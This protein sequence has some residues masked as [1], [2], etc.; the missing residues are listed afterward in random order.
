MKWSSLNCHGSSTHKSNLGPEQTVARR[1]AGFTLIEMLVVITIIGLLIALLLPAVQSARAT[2]RRIH[3]ANNLKQ[4]GTALHSFVNRNGTV[5]FDNGGT[6]RGFFGSLLPDLEQ[7]ALYNS[8]NAQ[9]GGADLPNTTSYSA[10]LAVFSCP[11]ETFIDNRS[12]YA[13]NAG[14]GFFSQGYDGIV[15]SNP[16]HTPKTVGFRDLTD[17]SSCTAAV[18]EWLFPSMEEPNPRRRMFVRDTI[19]SEVETLALFLNHCRSLDNMILPDGSVGFAKG[20]WYSSG[21]CHTQYD[22]AMLINEPSCTNRSTAPNAVVGVCPP[23]SFHAG[24]A[25]VLLMDGHVQF[26]RDTMNRA[27]WQGLGTRAGGEF[28]TNSDL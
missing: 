24:G 28:I 23:G 18:S 5:P 3:C 19:T 17:G 8:F 2:A 4:I 15:N 13:G 21:W 1:R 27:V 11:S 6:A 10:R 9:F 14:V 7:Q 16:N 22:H 25:N 12:N 26:F 20:F